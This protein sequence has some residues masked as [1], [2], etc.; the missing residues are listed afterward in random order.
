LT[1]DHLSGQ[2]ERGPDPAPEAYLETLSCKEISI[3]HINRALEKT[4]GKIHGP[5]GAA[6]LLGVNPST[7]RSRMEKLSINYKRKARSLSK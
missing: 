5:E 2:E 7:L 6:Q 4:K 3:W 1:F